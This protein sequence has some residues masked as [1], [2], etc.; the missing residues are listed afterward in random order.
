MNQKEVFREYI[1]FMTYIGW[2][3][4]IAPKGRVDVPLVNCAFQKRDLVLPNV[5]KEPVNVLIRD[6]IVRIRV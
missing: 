1:F 3:N 5:E 2:R 6:V 4:H